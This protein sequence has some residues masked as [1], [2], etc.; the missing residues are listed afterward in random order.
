MVTGTT[1][2]KRERREARDGRVQVAKRRGFWTVVD[3]E[4]DS[5]I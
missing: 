3:G 5:A 1:D 2:L 4:E